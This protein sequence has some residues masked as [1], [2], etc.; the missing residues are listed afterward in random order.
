MAPGRKG[1]HLLPVNRLSK[2]R[3]ESSQSAK[4]LSEWEEAEEEYCVKQ[5]DLLVQALTQPPVPALPTAAT[6]DPHVLHGDEGLHNNG[7]EGFFGID[8]DQPNTPSYDDTDSGTESDDSEQSIASNPGGVVTPMAGDYN[9]RRRIREVQQWE[10]ILEPMFKVFMQCKLLTVDWSQGETWNFD[11]KTQ[12]RCSA[13]KRRIRHL[14]LVDILTVEFCTCQSDQVRL[15]QMGYIGGSPVLPEIAFSLRLL[16]LHDA[17]WRFCCIRTHPFAQALD[18]FHRVALGFVEDIT[19]KLQ[20]WGRQF[21]CAVDAYRRLIQVKEDLGTRAMELSPKEKLGA[22]CPR[23][24]GEN[25]YAKKNGEPDYVVCV[26][27]NFQQRRH[28]SASVEVKEIEIRYPTLF[29]HP[30][31]VNKWENV[32]PSSADDTPD[33]C[34]QMHTAANDSRSAATWRACDDTGLL[35]MVCRHDHALAFVNIVQSGEKSYFA[36]SLTDW[37]LKQLDEA[38]SKVLFLYD[39]GCN[40]EKGLLD[41]DF[42]LQTLD[43]A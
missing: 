36:H 13:A 5:C 17:L 11:S 30:T 12:C 2:P 27:G 19:K 31:Q 39:I 38:D 32:H 34:T 1:N 43:V 10:N 26:D 14:E 25:I 35:A 6:E 22:N 7:N 21:S 40:I 29:L 24:F 8:Y 9:R 28:M 16:R 37:L 3:Q 42:T 4:E 15:I 41:T 20:R 18:F 33:P 23:C